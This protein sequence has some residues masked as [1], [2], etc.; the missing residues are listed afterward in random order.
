VRIH[1]FDV[2]HGFCAAI[3]DDSGQTILIDCGHSAKTGF[4]PSAY[5]QALGIQ[6]IDAL[7]I[8]NYDQDHISDLPNIL[9]RIFIRTLLTNDSL[10]PGTL[11]RIKEADCAISSA[12]EALLHLKTPAQLAL[13]PDDPTPILAGAGISG[14][15]FRYPHFVETNNLSVITFLD[16]R[17]M[18]IVFPGD[19]EK[20]GW[21]ALLRFPAIRERLARVNIFVA[22]HHGRFNGYC[23]DVFNY[24]SPNI[25]IMSDCEVRYGSQDTNQLYAQH[26]IG[27]DFGGT[28]RKVLTTRKEGVITIDDPSP[29][30]WGAFITIP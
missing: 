28:I 29:H 18:H 24:C 4:R 6:T 26:A 5:L 19:L 10:A 16:Y 1:I 22:S 25:V 7:I 2:D 30:H 14:Y 3:H 27:I 9:G 23:A 20:D 15:F 21:E 17:N 12:M 13:R 8:S 11:R